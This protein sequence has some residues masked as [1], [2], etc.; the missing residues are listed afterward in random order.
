MIEK[1][2]KTMPGVQHSWIIK[3]KNNYE[4]KFVIDGILD[5]SLYQ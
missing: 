2:G 1:D 4:N 5:T 3:N